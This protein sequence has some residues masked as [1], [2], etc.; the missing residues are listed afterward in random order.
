M[1]VFV[2]TLAKIEQ[3]LSS[4]LPHLDII[5]QDKNDVLITLSIILVTVNCCCQKIHLQ[6]ADVW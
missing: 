3:W 1:Q 5:L 2:K 6:K 4:F